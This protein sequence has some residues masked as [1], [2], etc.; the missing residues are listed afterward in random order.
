MICFTSLSISTENLV[1]EVFMNVFLYLYVYSHECL[2]LIA[3]IFVEGRVN[4]C[5]IPRVL[6]TLILRQGL[7]FACTL[8]DRLADCHP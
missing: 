5:I 1:M 2:Q 7:S 4:L 8:S 6:P 3:C